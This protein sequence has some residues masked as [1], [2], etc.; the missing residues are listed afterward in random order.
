MNRDRIYELIGYKGEYNKDVKGKLRNLLKKY[1]PDNK[2]GNVEYFKLINE[3]KNE[4]E[5]GKSFYKEKNIKEKKKDSNEDYEYYQSKITDIQKEKNIIIDK[6]SVQKQKII[7]LFDKYNVLNTNIIENNQN[8]CNQKDSIND[9]KNYK[10][11]YIIYLISIILVIIL[12]LFTKNNWLLLLLI[13]IIIILGYNVI[14]LYLNIK[15]LTS[16]SNKYLL[17]NIE[18]I[19]D[20]ETL[21]ERIN[22]EKKKLL[23]LERQLSKLDY[24]IRFYQN[25]INSK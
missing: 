13:L 6:I 17:K 11:K 5:K 22:D 15:K 3:V 21:K 7:K 23:V 8:L 19:K 24:D 2:K 16:N 1:H 12:Y 20:L 4:L 9:L 25:R 14:N 10:N 18:I